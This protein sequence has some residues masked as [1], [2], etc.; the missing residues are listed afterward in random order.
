MAPR[1]GIAAFD[2]SERGNPV[3]GFVREMGVPGRVG[4]AALPLERGS[5]FAL[6]LTLGR[7]AK[8]D[9]ANGS[10][11]M[12]EDDGSALGVEISGSFAAAVTGAGTTTAV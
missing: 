10:A 4:P 1:S 6:V 5:S 9:S 12:V 7:A 2:P 11:V 3:L 8:T